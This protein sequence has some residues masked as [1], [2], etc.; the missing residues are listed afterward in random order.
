MHVGKY[1]YHQKLLDALNDKTDNISQ[2]RS[3]KRV[4]T[5]Q[6]GVARLRNNIN[7]PLTTHSPMKTM[8]VLVPNKDTPK[9][10]VLKNKAN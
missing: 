9:I 4:Q 1:E 3:N 2:F 7:F 5:S 8:T 10:A 6:K